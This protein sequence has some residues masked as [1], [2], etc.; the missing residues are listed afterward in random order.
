MEAGIGEGTTFGPVMK[1]LKT[2]PRHKYGFDISWSRIKECNSFL[3][4]MN[5]LDNT[6]TFVGDLLFIPMKDNAV[7]IVYTAHALEP[8]GGREKE[9]LKELYRVA[10]KYII[11]FEPAYEFADEEQKKRMEYY[12]YIKNLAETA[13]ELGYKVMEHRLLES[14]HKINPAGITVIHK[15][16]IT[17]EGTILCDPFSKGELI[18]G[19]SSYFS[20]DCLVA[21]PIV[22]K[23]PC[24]NMENAILAT[25]YM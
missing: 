11:L 25:K 13:E 14:A 8:N 17:V 23:I 15:G 12:G 3:D 4:A 2:Q 5:V 9:L 10:S 22:E 18:K 6:F 19:E 7:D 21:Y 1:R 16:A 20:K 24:L